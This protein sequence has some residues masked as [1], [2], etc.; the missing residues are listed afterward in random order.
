MRIDL[1]KQ[2]ILQQKLS[3]QLGQNVMDKV[4]GEDEDA[5]SE[6]S[7]N[8]NENELVTQMDLLEG[9]IDKK[10]AEYKKSMDAR[11]QQIM[12][13]HRTSQNQMDASLERNFRTT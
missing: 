6:N 9:H 10:F 2:P 1:S 4:E 3:M 12:F 5:E 11:M 13:E 8:K 7:Q